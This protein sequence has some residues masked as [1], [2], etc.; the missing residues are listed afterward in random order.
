[1]R[2]LVPLLR[3]QLLASPGRAEDDRVLDDILEPQVLAVLSAPGF[4]L[5]VLELSVFFALVHLFKDKYD[6][7]DPGVL[8]CGREDVLRHDIVQ[9]DFCTDHATLIIDLHIGEIGHIGHG[10]AGCFPFLVFV[11]LHGK[12][13]LLQHGI[14]EGRR[15]LVF[16][17]DLYLLVQQQIADVL[18]E[19]LGHA[20]A[21][22]LAA[23]I[24]ARAVIDPI[25][26][27]LLHIG[28]VPAVPQADLTVEGAVD[29][30]DALLLE[31][32]ENVHV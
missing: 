1:M 24:V 7:S 14:D 15:R 8:P 28:S 21:L 6:L 27:E 19:L 2:D 5:V 17:G 10:A 30:V 26:V 12:I 18:A 13:G 31:I 22:P 3:C 23:L 4:E 16:D 32:L 29:R 20:E 11:A 9:F 25:L